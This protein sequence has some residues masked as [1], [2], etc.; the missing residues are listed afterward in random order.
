MGWKQFPAGI[1]RRQEF[2][3]SFRD[4]DPGQD[5]FRVRREVLR[6]MA[7]PSGVSASQRRVE[8][9]KMYPSVDSGSL[10]ES[11]HSL[12]HH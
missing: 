10:K 4:L 9:S 8:R 12:L 2:P 6:R 3:R 5:K 11:E 7:Y 1:T